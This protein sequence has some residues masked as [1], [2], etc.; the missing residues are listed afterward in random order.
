MVAYQQ[1]NKTIRG[2]ILSSQITLYYIKSADNL[3]VE[4]ASHPEGS[5]NIPS[6]FKLQTC[7]PPGVWLYLC[8]FLHKGEVGLQFIFIYS[9]VFF[10]CFELNTSRLAFSQLFPNVW[11]C[12]LDESSKKLFTSFWL[13]NFKETIEEWH[14]NVDD[15]LQRNALLQQFATVS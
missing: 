3:L 6:C 2:K 12:I 9:F 11:F 7:G 8:F 10:L 5:S 1:S 15:G 4:L 13:I 14:Q